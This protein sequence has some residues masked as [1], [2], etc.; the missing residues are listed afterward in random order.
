[1]I[2]RQHHKGLK[3]E[4]IFYFSGILWYVSTLF[5]GAS[6][7]RRFLGIP[8]NS[9]INIFTLIVSGLL[10]VKIIVYQK[11]N[12]KQ[13]VLISITSAIL[14]ISVFFT[15]QTTL[16]PTFLFVVAA[17][18]IDLK[19]FLKYLFE[20]LFV[21]VI[22]I[23]LL[24]LMGTIDNPIF[25][26]SGSDVIRHSLGFLHPN[27]LGAQILQIC[28]LFLVLKWEKVKTLDFVF[29][30][31]LAMVSHT[32]SDSR[33]SFYLILLMLFLTLLYKGL[34]KIQK[35]TI[36]DTIIKYSTFFFP[37][38]S[39]LLAH[40]YQSSH[41]VFRSLNDMFTG[42]LALLHRYYQRYGLSIF[43]QPIIINRTQTLDNVYAY[44]AISFGLLTFLLVIIAYYKCI[45][46]LIAKRKTP[47]LISIFVFLVSG[48]FEVSFFRFTYNY[49]LVFL[50][51]ALYDKW[52]ASKL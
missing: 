4:H 21:T 20:A 2:V 9:W 15:R 51:L 17:K 38:V 40:Y 11:Y 43:G 32:F 12:I 46:I 14:L 36:L 5:F 49:T 10:L 8:S 7:I 35:Q 44:L 31:T 18:G 3:P 25:Q 48:L 22:L 33:T 29:I 42:R 34:Y 45:K 28:G 19:K 39:I 47:I 27:L 30:L 52:D 50:S 1:M 6:T 41:E 23:I 37:A 13:F 16:L 26:R 24:A